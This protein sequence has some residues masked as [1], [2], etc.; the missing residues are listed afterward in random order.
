MDYASRILGIS[1]L[2][3]QE[4][5][6]LARRLRCWL[7]LTPAQQLER[8][9]EVRWIRRRLVESHLPLVVAIARRYRGRGLELADLIQEGNLGLVAVVDRFDPERGCRFSAYAYWWIR[10]SISQA[11]ADRGRMIR[12]PAHLQRRMARVRSTVQ[13]RRRQGE[14]PPSMGEVAATLGIETERLHGFSQLLRPPLSL[15]PGEAPGWLGKEPAVEA[16]REPA[17]DLE[18]SLARLPLRERELLRLRYGL[19]DGQPCTLQKAAGRFGVSRERIRQLEAR[20]FRRLRL[21]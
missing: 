7:A 13:Q 20:A 3:P 9:E 10:R 21:A 4:E 18:G 15:M 1:P 12:L 14:P 5:L 8:Q 6:E 17:D 16:V 19:V 2:A 11:I